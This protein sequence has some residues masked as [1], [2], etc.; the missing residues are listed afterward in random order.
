M[1]TGT[2]YPADVG[3]QVEKN[4]KD[5]NTLKD[6]VF[7]FSNTQLKDVDFNDLTK[8]GFYVVIGECKNSPTISSHAVIV[9]GNE[10]DSLYATQFAIVFSTGM[11]Y[12]RT[13]NA[14]VW[15]NWRNIQFAE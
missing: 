9:N 12:I 6:Y 15:T 11:A 2:K 8:N 13:C 7:E 5:I 1:A 14:G 4:T 3:V 10:S